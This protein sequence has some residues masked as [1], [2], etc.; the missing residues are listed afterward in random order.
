MGLPTLKRFCF[1]CDLETGGVII[2]K[3]TFFVAKKKVL[4]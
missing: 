1:C 4:N 3:L 2:G